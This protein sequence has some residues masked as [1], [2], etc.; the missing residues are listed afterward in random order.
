MALH[1]YGPFKN[2]SLDFTDFIGPAHKHLKT[3]QKMLLSCLEESY[4]EA[5]VIKFKDIQDI[6][7]REFDRKDH[8][9]H[10]S[11]VDAL[12]SRELLIQP[13]GVKDY[14]YYFFKEIPQAREGRPAYVVDVQTKL[15][16]PGNKLYDLLPQSG[17]MFTSAITK[18]T[19]M[20]DADF[21]AV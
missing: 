7:R 1:N 15:V 10:K 8:R 3:D 17:N 21:Q 6:I 5:D 4:Q 9:T 13:D 2:K 14:D 19:S 18:M 20:K 12:R 16:F 11:Y